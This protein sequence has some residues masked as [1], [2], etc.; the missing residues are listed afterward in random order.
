MATETDVII[1]T[2]ID[3]LRFTTSAGTPHEIILPPYPALARTGEVNDR[4]FYGY[5]RSMPLVGGGNILWHHEKPELKICVD[6]P[7]SVL[8][9]VRRDGFEVE[10]IMEHLIARRLP[11]L[12]YKRI[13]GAID[14]HNSGAEISDIWRAV[15]KGKIK[16][17]ARKARFISSVESEYFSDT[18]EFGSRESSPRFTRFYNKGGQMG[19]LWESWLRLEIEEKLGR[20]NPFAASVLKHGRAETI[21]REIGEAVQTKIK[22]FNEALRGETA[23][24]IDVPRPESR[25]N[26]FVLET[27][28]PFI[29]NHSEELT[30]EVKRKL[31]TAISDYI[32]LPG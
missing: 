26:K 2:C 15:E 11:E 5:T 28:I 22:W 16:S 9:E 1:T 27:I 4:G 7:G 6:L 31:L 24:H 29:G 12:N 32:T 10:E 17:T 19:K 21:R 30:S 3:W 14:I 23:P 25:P 8:A 18:V 13:D 20:V